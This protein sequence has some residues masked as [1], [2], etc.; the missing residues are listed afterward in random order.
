[1]I[2]I[3]KIRN[4]RSIKELLDFSII[5]IN[6]PKDLKSLEIT[7]E[8]GKI[9]GSKKTGNLGTLDIFASG[10]LPIALNK[11][12]RLSSYFM[13]QD[14]EYN[15]KIK[16]HKGISEKGLLE[17]MK[18]FLGEIIQI[19][20]RKSQVKRTERKKRIESFEII[21][22]ENN[23]VE[24]YC[25]VESGTYIRKLIH[26]LGKNIG[27]AQLIEL[28]RTRAGIFLE[29]DAISLEE[30]KSRYNEYKNG[31]D[32]RLREI[33]IPAEIIHKIIPDVQVK[34]ESVKS[35]LNGKPVFKQDILDKELPDSERISIFYN[36]KLIEIAKVVN[37]KAIA[38][39]EV[40]F[41]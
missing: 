25:K 34:E 37:D 11:A 26:D 2:N 30:L 22:K 40:V 33:L 18:K 10:V 29:K 23:I 31:D 39:P 3:E 8:V 27:G 15:G 41:N 17:E 36:D 21:K 14:K 28:N 24:F 35:L 5:I 9:L 20:P 7:N 4:E 13:G 16:L 38:V 12:C 32:K 19:P 1:M 6:K